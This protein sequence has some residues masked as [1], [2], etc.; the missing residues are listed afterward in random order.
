MRAGPNEGRVGIGRRLVRVWLGAIGLTALVLAALVG[1]DLLRGEAISHLGLRFV[2]L[3]SAVALVGVAVSLLPLLI[4]AL[5]IG[6]RTK[7]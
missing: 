5:V 3:L 2:L 4:V 1:Y 7:S 6:R